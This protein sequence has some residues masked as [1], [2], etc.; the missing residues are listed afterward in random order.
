MAKY[1]Q[2]ELF[3]ITDFTKHL[4]SVVKSIKNHSIE[5]IGILKNNKLE[6]VVISTDEYERLKAF[7][8]ILELSEH[9]HIYNTIQER[10]D[11]P[12]SEYLSME[13]LAKELKIDMNRL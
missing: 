3:S 1:A 13:D 4:G 12:L 2:N 9:R 5:K 11:T 10:K 7:E 6:A 8:E